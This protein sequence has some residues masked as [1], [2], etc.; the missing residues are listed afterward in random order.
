M[1]RVFWSNGAATPRYLEV[2]DFKSGIQEPQAF[3]VH[4]V[5]CLD[6][7]ESGELLSKHQ[8][9]DGK[10]NYR[11]EKRVDYKKTPQTEDK[12]RERWNSYSLHSKVRLNHHEQIP[13]IV[14]QLYVAFCIDFP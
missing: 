2:I 10:C 12:T 11:G 6:Y 7:I 9:C 14:E 13:A 5:D 3:I 8:F 1:L 4:V